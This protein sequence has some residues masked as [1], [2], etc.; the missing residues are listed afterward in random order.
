MR[1]SERGTRNR[2]FRLR[3]RAPRF[4]FSE[5]CVVA[6]DPKTG[7]IECATARLSGEIRQAA[8]VLLASSKD[9]PTLVDSRVIDF[10]DPSAAGSRQPYPRVSA[11]P[12]AIERR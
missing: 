8:A 12:R 7:V 6:P 5:P 9:A 4:S 1:K 3:V 11:R 2:E 10:A